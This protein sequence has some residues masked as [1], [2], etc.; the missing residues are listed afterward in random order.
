LA[1]IKTFEQNGCIGMA[2][3]T[4]NTIQSDNIFES[5]NW[6][7]ERTV[8]KQLDVLLNRFK[9]DYVKIGLT[10][11][12]KQL[13]SLIRSCTNANPK[14]KIIWD[15]VL[16]TSS[17]FDFKIDLK[18]L[19]SILENIYL[20]TPNYNE[21]KLLSGLENA[22]DGAIE[23]SKKCKVLLKGGHNATDLG[24]DYLFEKSHKTSFKP[25]T[26]KFSEKHGTGCV[27]SS[28]LTAN[29]A[30]GYPIKKSILRSKR[31]IEH[32][33]ESNHTL[34]GSHKP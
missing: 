31:Y 2:V 32:F 6:I 16:S 18:D 3:Q 33:I 13:K 26:I 20:I 7:E 34:I 29:L 28:A 30:K 14:V 1:D 23:L 25:K 21:I 19:D 4:A 5:A 12:L 9:F 27:L 15:P 8:Q 24:K 11:N 22:E 17:G 10:P